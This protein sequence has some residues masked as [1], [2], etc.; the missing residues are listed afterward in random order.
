MFIFMFF[1]CT[2]SN[3]ACMPRVS[4]TSWRPRST[5]AEPRWPPTAVIGQQLCIGAGLRACR[6]GE[7]S[8]GHSRRG[9]MLLPLLPSRLYTNTMITRKVRQPRA[10]ILCSRPPGAVQ[11]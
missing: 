5:E 4:R 9:Q 6:P 2:S 11:T 8:L 7:G 1:S 3:L 10:N